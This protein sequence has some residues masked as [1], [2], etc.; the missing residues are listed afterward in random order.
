MT[1]SMKRI[2]FTLLRSSLLSLAA[3]SVAASIP[4][5]AFGQGPADT[6]TG[7]PSEN[8]PLTKLGARLKP[9][10]DI[11]IAIKPKG[12]V[13]PVDYAAEVFPTSSDSYA[14]RDWAVMPFH[15]EASELIFQPPYWE[16]TPLERYGQTRSP[17]L[18]PI[19]SGAHFFGSFAIIP[20]KIGIDR[21][22]D[23]ISTL[24]YYRPGS[25][26]PCVRQRLPF[27]W[28]AALMEASFWTGGQFIFP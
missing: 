14:N 5:I 22:H 17:A 24:G 11:S 2:S 12:D 15:W 8:D 28:D 21:T 19:I 26:A 1:I 25:A 20:Y 9:I 27:E 13:L 6:A 4:T 3:I 10:A 7:Q 23:H 18:Q 16:H